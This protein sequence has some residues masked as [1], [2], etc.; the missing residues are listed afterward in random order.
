MSVHRIE[1]TVNGGQ[2]AETADARTHLADFL[3]ESL[4]LTGTHLG[5][6]Q[7]VCG[8]CTLF[9][10]GR[11]TRSC[12]TLATACQGRDVRTVEGFDDDPLM[13]RLRG[14]FKR[15]HGLQCGYC[16]PGMLATAYDIVRRLPDADAARIRK[17]LAGNLCRCTGYAGIVA[18]IQDVLS[19][20]APPPAV[21]PLPRGVRA[22]ARRLDAQAAAIRA[23]M[24]GDPSRPGTGG[25]LPSIDDLA[26]AHRL[27]RHLVIA[28][29]VDAVWALLRDPSSVV[30]C[31]PGAALDGPA[32]NGAFAG[33]CAVALG[34]MTASFQGHGTLA[35]DDA[36]RK[37]QVVGRGRDRFSRTELDGMLDFVAEEEN[38]A[39]R[40]NLT[41]AYRLRGPLAQFGRPALVAELAD[42]IL[43]RT[44]SALAA[45]ARG[46]DL[47]ETGRER[48]NAP[49]LVWRVVL[50]WAQRVLRGDR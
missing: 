45:R 13:D 43:E 22:A 15:H 44:A 50:A 1:L 33:H 4:L 38:G 11:P 16:T 7:G 49:L 29:P 41:V 6:E 3:R 24:S 8:A 42:R 20:E 32:E 10:D 40:L 25:P 47:P 37:G 48:L 31:I 26:G 39:A 34:P 36:A 17:E 12:I 14:A 27:R 28:A 19:G 35:T 9:V 5:C 18:A 46:E 21:H 23:D 2:V 30:G